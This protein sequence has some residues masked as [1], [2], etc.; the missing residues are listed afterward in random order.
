MPQS[1]QMQ[2]KHTQSKHT[3]LLVSSQ[4]IQ[5]AASLQFMAQDTRID[6]LTA[7]CSLPDARLWRGQE[8]LT[9]EAF[10]IPLLEGYPW[11]RVRNYS[12]LPRLG[13]FYG[14]IN[15]GLVRLVAAR[16]CIVVFGH[17]YI[18]FWLAILTARIGGKPL[19]L[20]TDATS[21]T[22]QYGGGWKAV[23]KKRF[24]P[25]LYNRVADLVLVPSTASKRFVCSLGVAEDRVVITPYVVDNH[26]IAAVATQ[27]D[28]KKMRRE[29]QIPESAV[30][31]IFCAKFIARKRPMDALA[32]FAQ[33]DVPNSYLIM[34]G[35][36][37]LA[38]SLKSEAARLGIA[39]RVRFLG[40]VNYSRLPE[41][42][43][44]SNALIFPSEHEPYGLPVNEAM[45][46]GIPAIV[47]DRVGA[48]YDL[49]VEGETG[50]VYPCGDVERLAAL[51]K[52]ILPDR[53]R[54]K[55]MGESARLRMH[56]WSPRENAEAT[57]D[58]IERAIAKRG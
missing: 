22:P 14:L 53:Q 9:K 57:F 45:I 13:K 50:F 33:A 29:W 38:E 1:K 32:A 11:T 42:Y 21:L 3:A 34:V 16:D 47:S 28:R 40:L 39:D 26:R 25:F 19:L 37:P 4:P 18:S 27:T 30:A 51:L 31:L 49:V 2:A 6:V 20:T 7:Y 8:N 35:D 12:P 41:V 10:D 52:E 17:S 15:P 55:K 44:A 46:C 58:A 54:L 23:L 5:N 56:T 36:G 48:G 43:A 24:L